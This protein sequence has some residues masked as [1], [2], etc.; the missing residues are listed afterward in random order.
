MSLW[1]R[2]MPSGRAETVAVADA[3]A[4]TALQ[5]E[6]D[7]LG[8]V[9]ALH[10]ARWLRA[11][12]PALAQ[13]V[14]A[15]DLA[16]AAASLSTLRAFLPLVHP[17]A[18]ESYRRSAWLELAG[19]LPAGSA[20]DAVLREIAA[21]A[22]RCGMPESRHVRAWRDDAELGPIWREQIDAY[23]RAY[24]APVVTLGWG[25]VSRGRTLAWYFAAHP[26]LTRDR[27]ILHVAPEPEAADWFRTSGARSYT[28]AD[29]FMAGVD[30][31]VD[32]TDLPFADASF[33]LVLCHRVMEHVVDDSSAFAELFRVL[34]PAGL[35]QVSVPQ[36]VHRDATIDWLYPDACHHRHVRH[37]G[38]DLETRLAS[39]G[40]AVSVEDWLV[41]QPRERLLAAGAYPM[42]MIHAVKP[43]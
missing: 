16:T 7:D 26:D 33:D 25:K 27:R 18:I 38:R 34:G 20:R 17:P 28:T 6:L 12:F 19:S 40:F 43:D 31:R 37:Y 9:L 4:P 42:R 10:E 1:R 35:L 5:P 14:P 39:A 30:H 13:A 3:A 21:S 24:G 29:A 2:L 11:R 32:L 8:P 36:A 15:P 22:L 23:E 41:S